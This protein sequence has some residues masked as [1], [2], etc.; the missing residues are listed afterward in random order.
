M[1]KEEAGQRILEGN[2]WKQC[3]VCQGSG[4]GKSG[5]CT[6]ELQTKDGVVV[7]HSLINS[8]C[9]LCDGYGKI[10]DYTHSKARFRLGIEKPV[11]KYQYK[12]CISITDEAALVRIVRS[13]ARFGIDEII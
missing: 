5:P 7:R 9:H 6:I 1:T 13:P 11:L 8:V 3:V 4:V 2:V 10:E 12:V